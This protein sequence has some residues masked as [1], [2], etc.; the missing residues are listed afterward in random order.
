VRRKEAITH[1]IYLNDSTDLMTDGG[2]FLKSIEDIL[3]DI[4]LL[5]SK[6]TN[7]N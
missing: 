1:E 7:Y 6:V 2:K 4:Q 5:S 3:N